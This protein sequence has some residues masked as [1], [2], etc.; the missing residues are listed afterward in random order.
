[1]KQNLLCFL[2][3]FFFSTFFAFSQE[4]PHYELTILPAN[5]DS[6]NAHPAD[7][8]Y[9]P[10]VFKVGDLSYNVEARYKGSTT[11]N[12][13]KK[14]WAIKF[15]NSTNYFGVS[16][17][18]LHADYKDHSSMRNFLI[19]K[20]FAFMGSPASQ[21]KHV[22]Y[23]VNGEEYGVFTQ[24]EQIDNEYLARNGR[25]VVSLYK[26]NNHAALMAPA[27]RDEYYR[28]IWDIEAGGDPTYNELRVL[29]NK[30]LYWSKADFDANIS[31]E[32]DVDNFLNFFAVHFVFTD[33]D[34]FTKNIFLNKN[35]T[36][37]KFELF[38]WDNEG[39]FG[40]SA[41][42]VFDS[43]F[44]N[45]NMR[46]SHT[47]EYEVVFQR[48]LENPTYKSI[49]RD[50]VN[51]ILTD[52]FS[53]VDT[54]MDNTYQKIKSSVYADTHKEATNEE[55]ET[56]FTRLKWF[57]ANRKASLQSN[58]LPQRNVLTDFYC[59][60]PFPNSANPLVTF[61]IVSPVK[62][63]VNMFFADSVNFDS[64]GQ[65]F[66]FSRFELFDDGLHDDL[67]ANDLIYGNT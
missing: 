4:L 19:M 47:P 41:Y 66:K 44:V 9:Y 21:I 52:G 2:T 33:M 6:M 43:T 12:Y 8:V 7:E 1:M 46:D 56:E 42:G 28:I 29:F 59:S 13:P 40:N 3:L 11:L 22:T 61:R 58:E 17:I 45:Y 15:N 18:N 37:S 50:K 63:P 24:V 54:L 39:S 55:F 35:S 51:R 49:F 16:R 53:Y 64:M 48:L 5:L 32:I 34:N 10:A 31:N 27:V 30:C 36:S 23:R 38:P 20:L 62:Q 60:N 57:M 67:Q 65:P 14:S 26:S 25:S